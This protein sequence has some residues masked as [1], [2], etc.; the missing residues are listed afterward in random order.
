MIFVVPH[1]RTFGVELVTAL[2][3]RIE[4]MTTALPSM[5]MEYPHGKN[6]IV[7]EM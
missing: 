7:R 6:F 5:P 2:L 1:S 3:M 4:R